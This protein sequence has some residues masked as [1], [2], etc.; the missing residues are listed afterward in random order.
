MFEVNPG[1][2]MVDLFEWIAG[3]C[4]KSIVVRVDGIRGWISS[5][6]VKIW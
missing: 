1:F 5:I 6:A 3:T 4:N 2:Y